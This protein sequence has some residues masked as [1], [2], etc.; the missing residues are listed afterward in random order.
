M[1]AMTRI[2]PILLALWL[3]ACSRQ[4][5]PDSRS[6]AGA[7]STLP[8]AAAVQPSGEPATDAAVAQLVSRY[9]S[10]KDCKLVEG[11]EDEDW[12]IS[13]CPGL[14]GFTV[15]LN[16]GDAREDIELKQG[17][18]SFAELHLPLIGG[19]GF[20]ALG[21]TIEWRGSGEGAAFVPAMLIVRSHVIRDPEHPD[22][23][24]PL[25][26]V[27]DLAQRCI[28]GAVEPAAGQNEAAR[29]IADGPR[30]ACLNGG[31]GA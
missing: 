6:E 16:Y 24:T 28:V 8:A 5:E 14:G 9:T 26:Y 21:D 7:S 27:Y 18:K 20:N 17:G 15:M 2:A 3:A 19:G 22:R 11:P 30:R 29:T 12:S 31:G 25:L 1:P 23:Q 4:T 10:L 13:R